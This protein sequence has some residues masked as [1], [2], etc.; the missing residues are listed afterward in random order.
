VICE[1]A[2]VGLL[3][4]ST[5]SDGLSECIVPTKTFPLTLKIYV[6][7]KSPVPLIPIDALL[8]GLAVFVCGLVDHVLSV[9]RLTE[10]RNP[11]VLGVAI[12]MVEARFWPLAVIHRPSSAVR[13]NLYP[14]IF[15]NVVAAVEG[16]SPFA[17]LAST[18]SLLPRKDACLWIVGPDRPQLCYSEVLAWLFHELYIAKSGE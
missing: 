3:C 10:V 2:V 16:S 9:R 18:P 17:V 4:S 8:S 6:G 11:V 5:R 12:S 14:E 1:L 7:V 15:E 13:E